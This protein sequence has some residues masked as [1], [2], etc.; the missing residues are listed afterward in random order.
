MWFQNVVKAASAPGGLLIHCSDAHLT[1]IDTVNRKYIDTEK[2]WSVT[3]PRPQ[4]TLTDNACGGQIAA[5]AYST[6]GQEVMILCSDSPK[7]ALITNIDD[8]LDQW[9]QAGNL[10]DQQVF[11]EKGVDAL[12]MHLSTKILH[13]LMHVAAQ[14]VRGSS[15]EP[16]QCQSG[17][18]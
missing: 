13:E 14:W 3:A 17:P 9:R 4:G 18:Y 15:L 16:L 8:T 2:Q 5:F 1:P 12:G 7:G 6:G 11:Q 10:K